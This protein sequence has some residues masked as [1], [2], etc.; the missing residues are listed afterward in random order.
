MELLLLGPGGGDH[1]AVLKQRQ[2]AR[3]GL[4][5]F[6]AFGVEGWRNDRVQGPCGRSRVSGTAHLRRTKSFSKEAA[7]LRRHLVECSARLMRAR[8]AKGEGRA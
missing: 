6:W 1:E 5:G 2:L 8:G 3:V 4:S 7:Q